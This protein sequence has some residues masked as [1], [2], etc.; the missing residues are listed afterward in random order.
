MFKVYHSKHHVPVVG[1][2]LYKGGAWLERD[3]KELGGRRGGCPRMAANRALPA[4]FGE[5]EVLAVGTVLLIE[6]EPSKTLGGARIQWVPE[7]RPQP[8]RGNTILAA[9]PL[10]PGFILIP[11]RM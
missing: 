1:V 2:A 7:P 11:L 5:L 9:S 4:G 3:R 10:D 6:G 8:W